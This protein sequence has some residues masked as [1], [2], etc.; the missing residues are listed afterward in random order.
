MHDSK[1]R[2]CPWIQEGRDLEWW[3]NRTVA[4]RDKNDSPDLLTLA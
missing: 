1:D 2:A 4:F 3:L